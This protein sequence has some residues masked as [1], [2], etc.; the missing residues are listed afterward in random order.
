MLIRKESAP[1]QVMIP[2]LLVTR[3]PGR[4]SEMTVRR[5]AA[6][7]KHFRLAGVDMAFTAACTPSSS[8]YTTWQTYL[9]GLT[10][11]TL[12]LAEIT[13][14]K[15]NKAPCCLVFFHARFRTDQTSPI[16]VEDILYGD[17]G[18]EGLCPQMQ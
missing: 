4:V 9:G 13:F 15:S 5:C 8:P 7:E 2:F 3:K 6:Q 12:E 17:P 18:I 1:R 11:I 16:V 10:G 14:G